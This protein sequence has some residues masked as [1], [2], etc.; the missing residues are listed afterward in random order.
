[1]L[2]ALACVS[3]LIAAV[4]DLLTIVMSTTRSRTTSRTTFF[5]QR[6]S[7]I[8]REQTVGLLWAMAA[9]VAIAAT[10][11]LTLGVITR[12][13]AVRLSRTFSTVRL[14][15][16]DIGFS[17]PA[18]AVWGT[19]LCTLVSLPL[20]RIHPGESQFTTAASATAP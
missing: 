1:M 5:L 15:D 19:P 2:F 8:P 11:S 20:T 12:V 4:A 7:N 17:I 6:L 9:A 13:C 16:R 18:V 14:A 3:L 10:S